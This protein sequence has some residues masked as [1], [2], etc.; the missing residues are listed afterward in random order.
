M[1]DQSYYARVYRNYELQNP[2][3]KLRYYHSLAQQIVAHKNAPIVHDLGCAFGRFIGTAPKHW[4]RSASDANA[5]AIDSAR[6]CYPDV[7]FVVADGLI[8]DAD[9]RFDLVTAFD[10]LEHISNLSE[11]LR[12]IARQVKDGGYFIT[13]VPVYDGPLGAIVRL[14]DRDPTHVHKE[15]RRFW[16][17]TLSKD[18]T[19]V[20]KCGIARYLLP[21]GFYAHI[22]AAW[23][24]RFAPAIA[25]VCKK[26]VGSVA[27]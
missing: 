5:Y 3:R 17:D 25:L 14:L 24:W 10:V 15:S 16:I 7:S 21:G 20:S 2:R 18:F 9:A 26:K 11:T 27:P 23:T 8:P 4:R 1:F 12:D 13:V 22:A 19:I 6:E